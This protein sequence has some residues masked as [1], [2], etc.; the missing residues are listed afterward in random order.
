M[1]SAHFIK[2]TEIPDVNS[3]PIPAQQKDFQGTTVPGRSTVSI[4]SR[5]TPVKVLFS[6]L[7]SCSGY[8]WVITLVGLSLVF[9]PILT[10][11]I[12][13]FATQQHL[14]WGLPTFCNW[15]CFASAPWWLG[16]C[17]PLLHPFPHLWGLKS[18]P[19]QSLPAWKHPLHTACLSCPQLPGLREELQG[20]ATKCWK[21]PR[22]LGGS[23]VRT[24]PHPTPI[25]FPQTNPQLD[26]NDSL[27]LLEN[28]ISDLCCSPSSICIH[29]NV[30]QDWPRFRID[31]TVM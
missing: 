14:L 18:S 22:L 8:W 24:P 28:S 19:A 27:I 7:F 3:Q 21:F 5:V 12:S 26:T 16:F 30:I 2:T 13:S 10:E 17:K 29:S 31:K 6:A 15:V 11:I 23:E 20:W 1:T 9:Y 25:P 4:K